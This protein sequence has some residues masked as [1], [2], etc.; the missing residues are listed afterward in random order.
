MP[1][2]NDFVYPLVSGG[3]Y[4]FNCDGT[5]IDFIGGS[6]GIVP[7]SFHDIVTIHGKTDIKNV[8][9][10]NDENIT[11][12]NYIY[13]QRIY[14]EDDTN[15]YMKFAGSDV[16]D[17]YTGNSHE[18]QL[19]AD[20]DLHVDGDIVAYSSTT[21]DIRLKHNIKPLSSSL[22]AICNLEGITFDWKY[23]DETNIIGLVA[24]NVEQ[25]IPGAIKE[26]QLPFYASSSISLDVDG[27]EVVESDKALYK[28][29]NYDMIV[30]HL[31]ESIKELKLE[32]DELKL[33]LENK[34]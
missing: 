13:C 20:G 12:V 19:Q 29:I 31:I 15:T 33:K 28:T 17:W 8:L 24:Q 4:Y 16:I 30:P 22:Y 25:F 3:L 1:A 14:G 6:S 34:I 11:D 5:K 27:K 7:Y 23:R 26:K 2:G 18:M 21:S 9:D 32:I 10:M